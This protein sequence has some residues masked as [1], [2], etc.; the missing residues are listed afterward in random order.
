[1][2]KKKPNDIKYILGHPFFFFSLSDDNIEN[3]RQGQGGA[4]G[5]VKMAT[6]SDDDPERRRDTPTIPGS[7]L[8]TW[9]AL[10]WLAAGIRLDLSGLVQ[11]AVTAK[12]LSSD[13]HTHFHWLV[14]MKLYRHG[15]D[16]GSGFW[17]DLSGLSLNFNLDR[18][19]S[20]HTPIREQKKFLSI[21][22][23]NSAMSADVR[24]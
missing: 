4:G 10:R 6:T 20:E 19:A 16:K 13:P 18:K 11:V 15:V 14:E 5:Y 1:M 24:R 17:L 2:R 7:G 22:D 3:E 9:I 21:F 23:R 12:R 8:H